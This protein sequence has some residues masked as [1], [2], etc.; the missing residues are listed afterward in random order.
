[1]PSGP[2]RAKA[3]HLGEAGGAGLAFCEPVRSLAAPIARGERWPTSIP[4]VR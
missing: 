4:L 2:W 3:A 1:M